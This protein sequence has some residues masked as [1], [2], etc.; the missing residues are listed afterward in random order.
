MFHS[1]Q[2]HSMSQRNDTSAEY[3]AGWRR[4]RAEFENYRRRIEAEKDASVQRQRMS[5]VEPLLG[6][7]D[8][9][10]S[11]VRHVPEEI[12][13]NPWTQGVLHVMRQFEQLLQDQGIA[14]IEEVDVSFEPAL[15]EAI[16]TVADDKKETGQVVEVLQV[17]YKMGESVLRPAKVKIVE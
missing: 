5:V 14:L 9:F 15:H 12:K 3:L 2:I 10:K 13:D 16:E 1:T 8:N 6:V 4:E 7:A 11:V 17:G